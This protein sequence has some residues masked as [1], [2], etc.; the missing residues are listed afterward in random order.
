MWQYSMPQASISGLRDQKKDIFYVV[1]KTL[2]GW[3]KKKKK[4]QEVTGGLNKCNMEK[5]KSNS[6]TW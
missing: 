3:A 2:V 1:G 6:Y 5:E 4:P